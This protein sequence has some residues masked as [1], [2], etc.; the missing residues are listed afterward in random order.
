MS[1]RRWA[2]SNTS[3]GRT[4]LG[5]LVFAV[6]NKNPALEVNHWF[7][8]CLLNCVTL[9]PCDLGQVTESCKAAASASLEWGGHKLMSQKSGLSEMMCVFHTAPYT[10]S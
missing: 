10:V 6:D 5:A 1:K 2:E 9:G 8:S 4:H 3:M 7:D